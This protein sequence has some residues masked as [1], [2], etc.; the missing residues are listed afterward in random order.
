[1]AEAVTYANY[2]GLAPDGK[3][4]FTYENID[5]ARTMGVEASIAIQAM[6][7]LTLTANYTYLDAKATSGIERPLA[8]Q[9]E[10]SANFGADWQATDKWSF[11][12]KVNYVG[13]Q[14]T[15]VPSNGDLASA[16]EVD[17]YFT[18]DVTTQYEV[19]DNFTMRAGILNVTDTEMDRETWSDFNI[20]GRRYFL[21][22]TARF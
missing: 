1:M 16:G 21:S 4:Q 12:L 15:Y 8:Y 18:A 5:E 19:N 11:G 13:E 20:D 6:E 9:P 14:Y 22:A 17:A 10:H 3:P 7:N 2:V